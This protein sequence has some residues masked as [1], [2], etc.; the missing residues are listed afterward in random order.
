MFIAMNKTTELYYESAYIKEFEAVVVSCD[1]ASDGKYEIILDKTAFFPEQGGQTS[2]VGVLT[3]NTGNS[4]NVLHTSIS[5]EDNE[6]IIRHITDGALAAGSNVI[7][8]IDWKH[9]FSNMQ[10]HTGEHIFSGIVSKRFG[11]DNVGFHLS[12]S[13][14]TM[15]YS[16]VLTPDDI[17][18]IELAV[19]RAIWENVKVIAEFPDKDRLDSIDYRSK[20]ELTGDVR[21]VTVEG[22]D[23]CAC[24]APHVEH[25]GEIGLLKVVGLQN[26]KKG[27]R[28]S[29]LCGER[30]LLYLDNE[31]EILSK[32]SGRFTTSTDK[33]ITSVNKLF[34][35]NDSLKNRLVNANDK[36]MEYEL[37]G[38]D[39]GLSNVFLVKE[40]DFDQVLMRKAVNNLAKEH[41]GYCGIFAGDDAGYR[42]IIASGTEKRDC[43]NALD[44]LKASF[45]V[46]GGGSSAMIQG[47][48][49]ASDISK[50][51]NI[52]N[53][54]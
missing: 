17:K 16:G 21:I 22:Y 40:K 26:Y 30:A 14:V 7:G 23:C 29:I 43:K 37:L 45:D 11:Y 42:F 20:K 34:E 4:V 27:V 31:H 35:D 41:A 54:L 19:N 49:A 32:L 28:V 47:N 8:K 36:L 24:C 9:R 46:K 39:K 50:V 1:A 33:V 6:T 5:E 51:L 10:Q 38:I 3:D 2:D 15:D 13:E 18:D 53:N 52:C 25:T 44:A 48:I 12:D